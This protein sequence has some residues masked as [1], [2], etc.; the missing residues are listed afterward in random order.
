M[1]YQLHDICIVI[2]AYKNL[3]E[4]VKMQR[5]TTFLIL[6]FIIFLFYICS[7]NNCIALHQ[8]LNL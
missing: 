3:Q 2:Q 7:Q 1:I 5:K 6:G 8:F 4:I